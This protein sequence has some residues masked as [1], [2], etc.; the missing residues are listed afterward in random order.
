M[1][2]SGPRVTGIASGIF[3]QAV[4]LEA[5]QDNTGLETNAGKLESAL[6]KH[7]D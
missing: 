1:R 7:P 4:A 5:K 3:S 2:L 6:F